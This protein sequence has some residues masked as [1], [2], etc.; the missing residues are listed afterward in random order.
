VPGPI[1][2]LEGLTIAYQTEAGLLEA[3]RD[4]SLVVHPEESYGLVGESGSGKTTLALGAIRYLPPNGRVLSGRVSLK[5]LDLLSLSQREMRRIWGGR[6][7]VVYQSPSSA[8]NPSLTIGRQLA[9][10]ARLHLGLDRKAAS[11]RCIEML[12]KVAMPDPE[13]VARRYPHQLSGGMLQRC[14]VAMALITSPELLILDE[15]TTALDVTTQAVV[16][17]LVTTLKR[18]L[19]SAIVYIT[20]D[21]GVVARICD[22]IGVMYAGELMEEGA[23]RDL[24]KR[25]RHPYTLNLLRCVPRFDLAGTRRTLASIPGIIPRLDELPPGCIF[26]PRCRF[27]EEACRTAR[28]PRV[29]AAPEHL[30]ACRRWQI[31]PRPEEQEAKVEPLE[32]VTRPEESRLLE[33]NDLKEYFSAPAAGFS[34]FR[35][36]KRPVKA[37]DGVTLWVNRGRTLG[38][39]GESGSGKTTVART[40]IGL[41]APT[42]GRILLG[43]APL[44]PT[45]RRRPLET[46]RRMQMVFQNPDASLNPR[47]SVGEAIRRPIVLLGRVPRGAVSQ[48]VLELLEAV[49]L[50]ASYYD[51]LPGELSG[52]EKQRVAIA[53]AFAADPELILCDEPISSLDVSVQGAL[54]NLLTSLQERS[55]TSYLFISHDLAAVQHIS[56]WIAVMYLGR[57]AEW[58]SARQ[59]LNPPYHPYT[60]ALLSAVP[61]ADPDVE[62]R[63]IRLRGSVPSAIDIPSGCRFHPRCPRFLGELCRLQEPP[64]REGEEH[65]WMCCHIPVD[66]LVRLQEGALRFGA[67]PRAGEGA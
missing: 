19:R 25:P 61:V 33:V 11:R 37:V 38:M 12:E 3:A 30:T 67:V 28:P 32:T 35:R 52:G 15:P 66:E 17:D 44:G 42:E 50:P 10:V 41:L 63:S 31:V 36:S 49:H 8:L 2:Q 40:V 65:H 23:I 58:G 1:L 48:R 27:V 4:V 59:V 53:R 9:E 56:D 64:W 45:L 57:M 29:E 54:M 14:V 26:A 16:L 18:E 39:V 21:L 22:R 55:G 60:E 7:G 24:Y 51:R 5:G 34:A 6:I 20:H 47:Q 62:Q 46:L 43:G 13:P